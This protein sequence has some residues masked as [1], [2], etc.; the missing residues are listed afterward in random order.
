MTVSAKMRCKQKFTPN[1]IK[2]LEEI[3]GKPVEYLLQRDDE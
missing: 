1:E 3:F 2:K